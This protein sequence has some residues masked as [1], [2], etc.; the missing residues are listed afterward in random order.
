MW[1]PGYCA[2]RSGPTMMVMIGTGRLALGG[3]ERARAWQTDG[4]RH[5]RDVLDAYDDD[6][7]ISEV[8]A[9]ELVNE[10]AGRVVR[11]PGGHDAVRPWPSTIVGVG[12]DART[13]GRMRRRARPHLTVLNGGRAD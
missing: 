7:V 11:S 2:A 3:G 6:R 5:G 13:R 8:L 4:W 1:R 12:A 9:D 10:L